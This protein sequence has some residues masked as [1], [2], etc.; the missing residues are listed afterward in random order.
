MYIVGHYL[1]E[2][3]EVLYGYTAYDLGHRVVSQ[4]GLWSSPWIH[5]LY[6]KLWN[7]YYK[8]AIGR[9]E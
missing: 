6:E 4:S 1:N 5:C 9:T 8:H 3:D 7:F 2:D